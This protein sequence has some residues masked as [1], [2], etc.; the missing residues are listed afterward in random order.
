MPKSEQA[1]LKLVRMYD[2][3]FSNLKKKIT[4]VPRHVR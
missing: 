2:F 4:K 1:R 3:L